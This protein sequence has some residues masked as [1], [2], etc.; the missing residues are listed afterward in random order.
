ML[1]ALLNQPSFH[2]ERTKSLKIVSIGGTVV[3]PHTL[4]AATDSKLLGASQAVAAFGMSEVIQVCSSASKTGTN[5]AG[6]AVC[7][8]Q[9]APG[10][11]TRI[12]KPQSRCAVTR[13]EIGE[14]HVGGDLVIEK[15][16]YGDNS[17]FYDDQSGHWIA[18]GDEAMMDEQGNI[19]ILGRYKDI[20][21]RGGENLSAALIENCLG[22]A[23]VSVRC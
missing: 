9:T 4:A 22:I 8:G 3:P 13:G 17:C 16:L 20:I 6:G 11:K 21:I 18:T 23:G 14:L 2:P 10:V 15:Y 5:L 12:C 1:L 19:F 7:L